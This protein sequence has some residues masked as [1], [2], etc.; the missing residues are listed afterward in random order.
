MRILDTL[1]AIALPYFTFGYSL[2][3]R[4]IKILNIGDGYIIAVKDTYK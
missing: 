4:N 1:A 2:S 3:P